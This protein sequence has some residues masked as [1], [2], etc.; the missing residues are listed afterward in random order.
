MKGTG[1]TSQVSSGYLNAKVGI[2]VRQLIQTRTRQR[3]IKMKF[4]LLFVS[5]LAFNEDL[6]PSKEV[7]LV[8]L[9]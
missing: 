6:N 9:I 4:Y 5:A 2:F 7:N 8:S 3:S 1:V